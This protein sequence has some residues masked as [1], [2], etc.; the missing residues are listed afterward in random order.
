MADSVGHRTRVQYNSNT[1]VTLMSS[2]STQYYLYVSPPTSLKT[3][4]GATVAKVVMQ[5]TDIQQSGYVPQRRRFQTSL[6]DPSI[7]NM[8]IKG[9]L[10][11]TN[12]RLRLRLEFCAQF[13]SQSREG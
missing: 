10:I 8:H 2:H 3:H 13:Q 4:W 11:L 5:W 9:W 12:L 6:L 1:T 7:A